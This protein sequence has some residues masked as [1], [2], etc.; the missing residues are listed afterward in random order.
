LKL[1]LGY[2][3]RTHAGF[4]GVD[5]CPPADIVTDLRQRWPWDDDSIEAVMALDVFEHLPDRIHTM[6]EL[7][8][9][10]QPGGRA[11]IEVPDAMRGAGQYQDPTHCSPWCRNTFMYFEWGTPAHQR[12][13]DRYGIRCAWRIVSMEHYNSVDNIEEVWKIR[14]ELEKPTHAR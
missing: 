7:W 10:L 12:F 4:L 5:I 6:N 2:G 3:G 1:D 14:V 13:A 9:V 11:T 8:R